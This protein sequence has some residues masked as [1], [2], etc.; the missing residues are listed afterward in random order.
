MA[1]K[2]PATVAAR[3]SSAPRRRGH[4][5]DALNLS[6]LLPCQTSAVSSKRRSILAAAILAHAGRIL[7]A[8]L[9]APL[10]LCALL[11]S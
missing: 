2:F 1:A 7:Q 10:D 9:V 6:W 5:L 11:P 8:G 4:L 3:S